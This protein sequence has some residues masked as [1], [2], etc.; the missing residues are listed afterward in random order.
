MSAAKEDEHFN[1]LRKMI[2]QPG[3]ARLLDDFNLIENRENKTSNINK[4]WIED[5]VYNNQDKDELSKKARILREQYNQFYELRKTAEAKRT[6]Q[7]NKFE[8]VASD[9]DN[10]EVNYY[11]NLANSTYE[12]MRE[13]I[14]NTISKRKKE[15]RQGER[16]ITST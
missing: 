10:E 16:K 1:K 4:K 13:N 12:E 14:D 9:K 3:F 2:D 5:E 11:E 6:K 7:I 8:H 15:K